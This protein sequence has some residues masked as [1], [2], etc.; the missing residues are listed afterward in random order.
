VLIVRLG[1]SAVQ[2]VN[3]LLVIVRRVQFHGN[4]LGEGSNLVTVVGD[5]TCRVYRDT[6]GVFKVKSALLSSASRIAAFPS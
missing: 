3:V 1:C 5:F 2:S 4:R 6:C